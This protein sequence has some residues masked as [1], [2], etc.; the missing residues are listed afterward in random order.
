MA[1]V[2]QGA[3]SDSSALS[4]CRRHI[5]LL[6]SL[7]ADN[8]G[9]SVVP[10]HTIL[11]VYKVAD[12]SLVRVLPS[13]EDE[14]NAAAFHPHEVSM[15]TSCKCFGTDMPLVRGLLPAETEVNLAA[16][17]AHEVGQKLLPACKCSHLHRAADL[18][19]C[20]QQTHGGLEHLGSCS[21]G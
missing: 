14:V 1:A 8:G 6:R 12:M 10:V 4:M 21:L 5:S 18:L 19:T 2:L 3:V 15:Q 13:A 9:A 7:V 17:H 11:E 20:T 16:Q